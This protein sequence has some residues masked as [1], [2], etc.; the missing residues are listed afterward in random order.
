MVGQL[1]RRART[2]LEGPRFAILATSTEYFGTD[3]AV[4]IQDAVMLQE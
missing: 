2:L 4:V 1:S 3:N